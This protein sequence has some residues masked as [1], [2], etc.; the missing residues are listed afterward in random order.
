MRVVAQNR[1]H[2]IPLQKTTSCSISSDS[3]SNALMLLLFCIQDYDPDLP[4]ELAAATG[5]PEISSDNRNKTDNG[6][7]D[8]NAQGRGPANARAPVVR[9]S[10]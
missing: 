1:F 8:F 7:V 4:P 3:I 5:H 2:M 9:S 10:L 6:H